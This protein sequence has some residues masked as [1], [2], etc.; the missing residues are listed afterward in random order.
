MC[1]E[2]AHTSPSPQELRE[3]AAAALA[4]ERTVRR[5]YSTPSRVKPSTLERVRRA[6]VQLGI[7]PPEAA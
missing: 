2:M 5:V 4:P 1:V 6:A 7:N 3:I